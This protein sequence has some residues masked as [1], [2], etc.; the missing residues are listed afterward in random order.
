MGRGLLEPLLKLEGL[1][2]GF[3]FIFAAVGEGIRAW[4]SRVGGLVGMAGGVGRRG[5]DDATG[6]AEGLLG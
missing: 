2:R 5:S 1:P 6:G 3:G 4:R